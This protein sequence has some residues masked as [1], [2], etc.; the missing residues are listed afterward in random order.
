M[1]RVGAKGEKELRKMKTYTGPPI[2]P[3]LSDT[4]AASTARAQHLMEFIS[5]RIKG[6]ILFPCFAP[7][8]WH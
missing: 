1:W 3:D 8:P 2:P 5:E 4:A 7:A 6:E